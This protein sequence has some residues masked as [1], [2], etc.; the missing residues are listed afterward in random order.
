MSEELN[1]QSKL[2]LEHLLCPK[3]LVKLNQAIKD[4]PVGTI[5]E[6]FATDTAVLTDIPAW[7]EVT[8]NELVKMERLDKVVRFLVRRAV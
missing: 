2:N 7:C 8:G 1:I 6:A 3:T 5:I 4:I